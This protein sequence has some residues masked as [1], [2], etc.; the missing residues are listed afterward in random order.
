MCPQYKIGQE[1]GWVSELV[2]MYHCRELKEKILN[3]EEQDI[4]K[5][6]TPGRKTRNEPTDRVTI[7]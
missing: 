4:F 2:R 6:M 1:A 7:Q 3:G 5:I